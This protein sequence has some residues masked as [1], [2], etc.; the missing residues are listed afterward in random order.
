MNMNMKHCNDLELSWENTTKYVTEE[1][2]CVKFNMNCNK[3][4]RE[5]ENHTRFPEKI[6]K[7]ST[8]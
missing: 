8:K 3:K 4:E 5:K 6:T 2:D 1:M 7:N